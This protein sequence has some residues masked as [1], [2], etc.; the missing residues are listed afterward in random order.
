MARL[1]SLNPPRGRGT[2]MRGTGR[3]S[4]KVPTTKTTKVPSPPKM[5]E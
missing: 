1:P 4:F 5:K 3:K 2:K